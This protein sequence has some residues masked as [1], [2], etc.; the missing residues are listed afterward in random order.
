MGRVIRA[1]LSLVITLMVALSC[2]LA[3]PPL[4][5]AQVDGFVIE[6]K[7][8]LVGEQAVTVSAEG[9][10]CA[11]EKVVLVARAPDW[12][13]FL[14]NVDKGLI[15][16]VDAAHFWGYKIPGTKG[17]PNLAVKPL[18]ARGAS[19]HQ[20]VN[21]AE[22]RSPLAFV[23]R[24]VVQKHSG[25]AAAHEPLDIRYRVFNR[26]GLPGAAGKLLSRL[27]RVPV[28][29]R[30]PAG[31]TFHTVSGDQ[32][33]YLETS[34]IRRSRVDEKLFVAPSDLRAVK[35]VAQLFVD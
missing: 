11:G 33:T 14:F 26:L 1:P 9:L 29:Q 10:R 34:S 8:L 19:R 28:K 20:G 25:D 6:Q 5:A 22:Y 16:S 4:F 15:F 18:A 2:L 13:A 27:Y 21:T 3:V 31:L 12:T 17:A 32:V 35:S 30:L 7:S 24:M 23:Q